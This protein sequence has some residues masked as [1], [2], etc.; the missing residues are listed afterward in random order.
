MTGSFGLLPDNVVGQQSVEFRSGNVTKRLL[1]VSSLQ[2]SNHGSGQF[3]SRKATLVTAH[4][5]FIK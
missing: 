1:E 2:F 3:E 5:S 4:T